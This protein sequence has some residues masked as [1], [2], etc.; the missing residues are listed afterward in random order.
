MSQLRRHSLLESCCS[1]ATGFV[2]S[3]L[4]T[5]LIYPLVG[6]KTT[7]AQN[8]WVVIAFTVISII[9]QYIWRRAFNWW[10]HRSYP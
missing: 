1:T 10:Q 5:F 4:A 8:F 3:F 2:L 6:L 9:R 7:T